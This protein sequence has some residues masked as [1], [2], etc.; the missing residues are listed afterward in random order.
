M[1]RTAI[2]DVDGTLIDSER[3]VLCSLQKMLNDDYGRY[4]DLKELHFVLG[5]PGAAALPRLG[6]YDIPQA[7][8]KWN[9]YMKDFSATV[10]VFRGMTKVL[11]YLAYRDVKTGIVTSKTKAELV[12]DFAPFGLMKYLFFIVCAD[13]T[14]KHKPEPEPVLKF[15]E[16]ANADRQSSIYIGDTEYDLQCARSAGVDFG[17]A[18]WGSKTPALEASHKFVRPDEILPLFF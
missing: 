12:T 14:I 2:F 16:I 9:S 6:I 10:G 4:Y 17:L 15:L 18:L 3:A 7:S 11:A 1:Y 5:I 13:D 8:E